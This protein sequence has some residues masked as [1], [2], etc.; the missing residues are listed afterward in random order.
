MSRYEEIVRQANEL[1]RVGHVEQAVLA[2]NEAIEEAPDAVDA[3]YGL[4]VLHHRQGHTEEALSSF[5]RVAAIAPH[6]ATVFNNLAVLYFGQGKLV[7]AE[8]AFRRAVAIDPRY[9]EAVYGLGKLCQRQER[10]VEAKTAFARCL[11]IQPKFEKACQALRRT[12]RDELAGKGRLRIHVVAFSDIEADAR[13]KLRWGDHWFKRELEK[14]F[15]TIGHDMTDRDPDVIVHLFGAP[16]NGLPLHTFN[17]IWIHSH[18]D[19]VTAELLQGYDKI[20][21]LSPPFAEQIR[22]WGLDVDLLI[23]ATAKQPV[24]AKIEH[25]I[26]FVGNA[27]G[28]AGRQIIRDLGDLQAFPYKLKVWG[29]GW[30]E[31]LPPKNFGGLY[32]DNQALPQLYASSLISL[33]DHHD[34]MRGHGFINPRLL[35]VLAS[36][37]FVISD[38]NPGIDEIFGDAVPQYESPAHLRALLD[39]YIAN[40]GERK[41]LMEKGRRVALSHSFEACAEQVLAGTQGTHRK[42]TKSRYAHMMEQAA[43]STAA[44]RLQVAVQQCHEAIALRPDR[45][46]TYRHIGRLYQQLEEWD[47]AVPYF[48]QYGAMTGQTRLPAFVIIG[49]QRCGTTSLYNYLAQHP[50]IAPALCKEVH[51][52]DKNFGRGLAWY[53]AFFPTFS[54]NGSNSD[55]RFVA[56]T[57]TGEATPYY[58]FH[59][60]APQRIRDVLPGIKLIVLLRNPVDRAYS[61]YHH[62]V[63]MGVETLSFGEAIAQEERRL[64]GEAAK[65]LADQGCF[66]FNHQHFSYK[67]RGVYV[68]QLKAWAKTFAKEQVLVLRSED[69]YADPASTLETVLDFLGLPRWTP[70][71]YLKY[72]KARYP[73]MDAALRR[74]LFG[75]FEPHNRRLSRFLGRDLGWDE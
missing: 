31:I 61:H 60:L 57:V 13:R 9:L 36:G 7:K 66:S 26:V 58:I 5:E 68:D 56:E 65:M 30:N 23:G 17:V 48:V 4:A 24:Q 10:F 69:F 12:K 11:E 42:P 63:R 38:K 41:A 64:A 71:T 20:F 29:E 44:G 28:H 1:A 3:L 47:K 43:R 74:E 6:D 14:A 51:F 15:Q 16:L 35:D 45:A 67:A 75:Y 33:N 50:R 49:G 27:K 37:G 25:D 22:R 70:D 55:G 34:D 19:W 72:N 32:F 62:E 8:D 18:P 40:P 54:T 53:R 73:D 2:Y 39:H 59:P 21:C 46:E 52:F